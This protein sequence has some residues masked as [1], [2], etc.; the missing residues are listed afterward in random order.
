MDLR[1]PVCNGTVGAAVIPGGLKD[2]LAH[3][4]RIAARPKMPFATKQENLEEAQHRGENT[5][6]NH[7]DSGNLLAANVWVTERELSAASTARFKR[8]Q[9][10]LSRRKFPSIHE[11]KGKAPAFSLWSDSR[12]FSSRDGQYHPIPSSSRVNK[13]EIVSLKFPKP[14]PL[15]RGEA[16]PLHILHIAFQP[17]DENHRSMHSKLV[18]GFESRFPTGI[19][20]TAATPE[21]AVTWLDE[22]RDATS[23][24]VS[25]SG[26]YEKEEQWISMAYSLRDFALN[27][28]IVFFRDVGP[29][30]LTG[31]FIDSVF[32]LD[33]KVTEQIGQYVHLSSKR[34]R[35]RRW[36]EQ[37]LQRLGIKP[38]HSTSMPSS[39]FVED[40]TFVLN[41]KFT[42]IATR[43]QGGDI[44]ATLKPFQER[45]DD[46]NRIKARL[47]RCSLPEK[48]HRSWPTLLV[49]VSTPEQLY[50]APIKSDSGLV[51][52][53]EFLTLVAMTRYRQRGW[54]CFLG[55]GPG[56][57]KQLT[58]EAKIIQSL[59]W[60]FDQDRVEVQE[61]CNIIGLR[62]CYSRFSRGLRREEEEE[63]EE[64]EEEEEDDATSV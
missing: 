46:D 10:W 33:W 47:R 43:R 61:R 2:H 50:R 58:M 56:T 1:S 34:G 15:N 40:G 26:H 30:T 51:I 12:L 23:V 6:E 60:A 16:P 41:Q 7:E 39:P 20:T 48:E 8:F 17:N 25:G 62:R 64:E 3:Q 37:C 42:S 18:E 52:D 57:G 5:R 38:S 63:K 19:V 44:P 32:G 59:T 27:G 11:W 36:R 13:S 29:Y 49:N 9:Q 28:G 22:T 4:A 45:V 31:N 54:I 24:V 14:D 55:F 53:R 21:E 35:T